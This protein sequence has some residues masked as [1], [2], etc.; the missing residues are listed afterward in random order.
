MNHSRTRASS[1]AWRYSFTWAVLLPFALEI[2][3]SSL[4]AQTPTAALT[5]QQS[6]ANAT[7]FRTDAAVQRGLRTLLAGRSMGNGLYSLAKAPRTMPLK[8]GS[9]EKG[10]I[11]IKTRELFPMGK[12]ATTF[13]SSVLMTG[14]EGVTVRDIRPVSTPHN[15]G[16]MLTSDTY[17]VGRIYAV[18]FD[19]GADVQRLC[20]DL[21]KNP[22]VEY[23]EPIYVYQLSQDR[24][25]PTDPLFNK[26][27]HWA[28][29]EAEKAWGITSGN[30]KTIIAICDSGVDYEHEDLK[31]NIWT[32]PGESGNDA[33]G[34]D[35]RTNG[36]DDD[37]NGKVDDWRGWD[38]V[39]NVTVTDRSASI[40]RPDNDPKPRP[41][42]DLTTDDGLQ[43]GSH[44]AGIAG[45]MANNG[46]GG[47]GSGFR[48]KILPIKQ[49]TEDFP[50]ATSV[51]LGY[52][53]ILYAAQMGA[54][55]VNCSWG[56]AGN[57]SQVAQD[58]INTAA[59]LGTLVVAA[60]GN[61]GVLMDDA[62]FPGSYD[63]VLSVGASDENDT[64]AG[65]SN[66][67]VKTSVFAP[68]VNI[69]STVNGNRYVE[70]GG[71][72]MA[73]PMVAGIAALVRTLHPEWTSQQIIQ[74]I[75]GTSDNVLVPGSAV[76]PVNF[77]G[78]LNAFRALNINRTLNGT[79]ENMPGIVRT[80]SS[81]EAT[82]GLL[83]SF[84]PKRLVIN[85]RNILSDASDVSVTLTPLD[86]TVAALQPTVN[87]GN[88]ATGQR[89]DAEFSIQLQTPALSSG[90][91]L[92]FG[93]FLI[94]Y[95]SG[96][97]VN[98]ERITI[99]YQLPANSATP[100]LTMS[101]VVDFG[102]TPV[103]TTAS[104]RIIN[105]G[106]QTIT[107]TA[108]TQAFTGTNAGEFSQ[109]ENLTG[110][111]LE[112]GAATTRQI[113]FTPTSGATG[114]R[115]A[116][117]NV[118]GVSSGVT[119]ARDPSKPIANGYQFSTRQEI[120]TEITD[121]NFPFASGG[122][123]LDDGEFDVTLP[124]PFQ[125]GQKTYTTTRI[126]S[127]GF[128]VFNPGRSSITE[129]N[130]VSSPI[131]DATFGADGLISGFSLDLW[132]LPD[133][134]IRYTTQ[135]TAPNRVFVVQW[136]R[137]SYVSNNTAPDANTDLNFQIRLYEGSNRIELAYDKMSYT[138]DGFL[139][140]GQVG[141]R[142]ASTADFN[143]RLV[144]FQQSNW[145]S[146]TPASAPT[147]RCDLFPDIAPPSGLVY[148]YTPGDF[149]TTST[150]RIATFQR[151]AQLSATAR[152]GGVLWTDPPLATGLNFNT[153]VR[154]GGTVIAVLPT[155]LGTVQTLT[156]TVANISPNTMNIT[157]LDIVPSVDGTSGEFRVLNQV[158]ITLAA[159]GTTTLQVAF[160]PSVV[161]VRE[162][163]LR[164]AYDGV[165]ALLPLF[166]EGQSPKQLLRFYND[167]GTDLTGTTGFF[168]RF[169]RL[170]PF[171]LTGALPPLNLV[172]IGTTRLVNL[173][174]VRNVGTAPIT[175]TSGTF[176]MATFNTITSPDFRLLTP[177]PFTIQPGTAQTLSIAYSPIEAGEKLVDLV[178]LSDNADPARLRCG[179][180]GGIPRA[181]QVTARATN[182]VLNSA[183]SPYSFNFGLV[184]VST[185]ATRFITLRNSSTATLSVSRID[186]GGVNGADFTV[187]TALPIRLAQNESFVL[188]VNFRPS[189]VGVRTGV[190]T[191][192]HNL[193]PGSET[194]QL[195]GSGNSLRRLTVPLNTQ[196]FAR[197]APNA[198]SATVSFG[199]RNAARETVTVS[200]VTIEGK[201]ANQFRFVRRIPDGTTIAAAA[202]STAT[203]LFA[204]TSNG[205]KQARLV[206]RSNAEF[207][208]MTVELSGTASDS[209]A[210]ATI[211]TLNA[212]A[213]Y[214]DEI[215]V[216]IIVRN[217]QS[218]PANTVIYAN[219]RLNAS[220]LQP[221]DAASTGRVFDNQR[222]VPLTLVPNGTDTVLTRLRYRVVLGNDTTT[223]L[224]LED[225]YATNA[226]ISAVSGR[227]TVT[228]APQA[229]LQKDAALSNA[230]YSA[231]QGAEVRIPIIV[232]NRHRIPPAEFLYAAISY[233]A[234]L[235]EPT[236]LTTLA[237]GNSVVSAVRTVTFRIPPGSASDTTITPTF[238]AAIGNATGS[239]ITV[240]NTIKSADPA[241]GDLILLQPSGN[242]TLTGVNNAG[243]QQLFFSP[244][245]TLII[246][247]ASPN[248]AS[249]AL[250]LTFRTAD[251]GDVTMSLS[252]VGGKP[253]REE[254]LSSL[255]AGEHTLRIPTS[256]LPSGSYLLTLRSA[257]GKAT[258]TLQVVR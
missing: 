250:T 214:G 207:P 73:S 45:S 42:R 239:T 224:R 3:S 150:P 246:V 44:V 240:V 233:N 76:R 91:A 49:A 125:F 218:L 57:F 138:Q 16:A 89:K 127:N 198:T 183:P 90:S 206:V 208:V 142:G 7:A 166:G 113:R 253:L 28:R 192:V 219:L 13:Q 102:T 24:V 180:V 155:T 210:R 38:F 234:T 201:D 226:T 189:D 186:F 55:V 205:V 25:T 223:V 50:N 237:A 177:L 196:V 21:M 231:A 39:G 34:R 64:P 213:Q 82:N 158:P 243:G 254:Q 22:E 85:V 10:A 160:S 115:T 130:F 18:R 69:I 257:T 140:R 222:V 1:R 184:N 53:G 23:A 241:F 86:P 29:I 197:T 145:L 247:Q 193:A 78:R 31:D 128:L 2:C 33:M 35:K 212:T 141:L 202:T 181:I 209:V 4:S 11:Y 5:K 99:F 123:N 232:R 188:T 146:S 79:G 185:T 225:A 96:S 129:T 14:L 258:Q 114:Q 144:N 74:H 54:A 165:A 110:V 187:N 249:D 169:D 103:P 63:N 60:A 172:P 92:D 46:V 230:Q 124:F 235:L 30:D 203:V 200:S 108:A 176:V 65:F 194:V 100:Q 236:N 41:Q 81:L 52:E 107:V 139:I 17:G 245:A 88:L 153:T 256:T 47:L 162:A 95:R 101:S 199:I 135:G 252:D 149:A 174:S 9:Y 159:N 94:T 48:C 117:F 87:I 152:S 134:T 118:I 93:D 106:N 15:S 221:L 116:N 84:E 163:A 248:P 6:R 229:F 151:S 217:G 67:G 242:F 121:D 26:Q 156:V 8:E 51:I 32:N 68:G 171:S 70:Y 27:Y 191:V 109:L 132:M 80:N 37:N 119:P 211:A 190:L 143:S 216:P 133:G 40:F 36:V 62:Y 98:Y 66:F 105:T 244:K 131:G 83:T 58:F 104:V 195:I 72:S 157:G 164:I 12:G 161:R 204:P 97:Y 173:V 175:V 147:D 56:G 19:P 59:A 179:S 182:G 136:K 43:H 167:V 20:A 137:A 126:V 168:S 148:V 71:T 122:A 111:T 75:R 215:S 220:L 238:R 112:A 170:P 154:N 251:D 178:L 77:F 255:K 61:Q 120:Y 228:G 227:L